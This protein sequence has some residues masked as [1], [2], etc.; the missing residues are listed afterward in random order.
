M[1]DGFLKNNGDVRNLLVYKVANMVS[2][3]TEYFVDRYVSYKLRTNDA[4]QNCIPK[5]EI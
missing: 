3:L 4:C 1:M 2:V 5:W